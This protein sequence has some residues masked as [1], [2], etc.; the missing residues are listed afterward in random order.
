VTEQL[1]SPALYFALCPLYVDTLG[2]VRFFTNYDVFMCEI[3]SPPDPTS[4][5]STS[6][7]ASARSL[8]HSLMFRSL[9]CPSTRNFTKRLLTTNGRRKIHPERGEK[10]KF[11]MGGGFCALTRRRSVVVA[12][13]GGVDSSVTAKLM[14]DQV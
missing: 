12:M 1:D 9:T 5:K 6:D 14:V 13:S 10:G 2:W 4:I 7:R 3:H 8:T 11:S